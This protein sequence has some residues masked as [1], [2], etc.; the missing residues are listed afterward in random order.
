MA[1]LED[2]PEKEDKP[3]RSTPG[4]DKEGLFIQGNEWWKKRSKHGR[5]KIFKDPKILLEACYEYFRFN[6]KDPIYISEVVKSGPQAG[7]I[8]NVPITKPLSM[9]GLCIFLGVNTTYFNDFEAALNINEKEI[10]ADYS[11]VIKHIRETIEHQMLTGASVGTYK[12]NIIARLVGL[13]DKSEQKV[14]ATN[15]NTNVTVSEE[16]ARDIKNKLLGKI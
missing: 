11:K 9:R 8:I 1:Q 5:D 16:E 2:R 7:R 3:K 15:I 6:K 10:D 13:T 14:T 12:E 4:K